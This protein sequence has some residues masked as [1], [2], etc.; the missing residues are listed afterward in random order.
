MPA[1]L[2]LACMAWGATPALLATSAVAQT[3]NSSTKSVRIVAPFAPAGYPDRLGRVIAKYLSDSLGLGQRVYVENRPGAGGIIGSAEVARAPADGTTLLISSLPSHVLAPL[4]NPN[5]GFDPVGGFS[6][7]AYVGGPPNAIVV[8]AK[9]KLATFEDLLRAA[10]G[11][12]VT[13]GTAGIGTAGHLLAAFVA[14]QGKLQFTHVP[15]NGPMIA[16]I[17]TGVVD[18]GS[19]TLSTVA[20][21]VEGG[22]LR[23]LAVATKD[24]LPAFAA[25]PTLKEAGFD[26]SGIG[27]LALS[28]PPRLDVDLIR[29]LNQDVTKMLGQPELRDLLRQEIIEPIAMTPEGLTEFI[30]DEIARWSP[31]VAAAGL[32]K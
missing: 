22:N 6:H 11:D 4:I 17:M 19:I 27:W 12:S 7:I 29:R 8:S 26:I 1:L 5:V 28:G 16:D 25:V 10:R 18:V 20:S 3:S 32:K 9:S 30:K 15:Y 23:L 13:Y 21:N 14:N 24:R 31:V 2:L